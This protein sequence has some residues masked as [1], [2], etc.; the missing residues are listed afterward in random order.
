MLS[1]VSKEGCFS[2]AS[3]A[4]KNNDSGFVEI[5]L[6]GLLDLGQN[7]L[8]SFTPLQEPLIALLLMR[9]FKTCTSQSEISL[10]GSLFTWRCVANRTRDSSGKT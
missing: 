10:Q 8:H 5:R 2:G 1:Q 4:P 9:E 6:L 3:W 7:F